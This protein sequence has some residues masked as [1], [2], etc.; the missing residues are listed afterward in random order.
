MV[1]DHSKL[2]LQHADD[3]CLSRRKFIT[4]ST[5]FGVVAVAAPTLLIPKRCHSPMV[6][7]DILTVPAPAVA[8][9]PVIVEDRMISMYNIHTGEH[10]KNCLFWS[11]GQ[12]N[13]QALREFRH[14]FR[15]HRTNDE[16][17][18]DPSLLRLL[19]QLSEKLETTEAFHLISGY[20][21]S[22]SNKSLRQQSCG[23]AE[24]SQHIYG[25]AADIAVPGRTMKQLQA[26]AKSLKSGGVGRYAQFVHVDTGRIRYWGPA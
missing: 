16:I 3:G 25:K 8:P 19:H 26:A 23:V 22:K 7:A 2:I 12:Y 18:V 17:D 24:N 6:A 14:F 13:P 5:M 20:R 10:L 9:Q 21:S 4:K 11:E 1:T 15:D